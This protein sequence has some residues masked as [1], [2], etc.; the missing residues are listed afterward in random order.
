MQ[1]DGPIAL[2]NIVTYT[3]LLYNANNFHVQELGFASSPGEVA[4]LRDE[5]VLR[6]IDLSQEYQVLRCITA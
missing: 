6:V 1:I 3:R 5:T 2:F 4:R